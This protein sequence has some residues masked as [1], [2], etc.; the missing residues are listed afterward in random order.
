MAI[1]W[2][3]NACESVCRLKASLGLLVLLDP[4][5]GGCGRRVCTPPPPPHTTNNPSKPNPKI[6]PGYNLPTMTLDELAAQEVAEAQAREARAR[7]VHVHVHVCGDGERE[8]GGGS[9]HLLHQPPVN[10]KFLDP[11][12]HTGTRRRA[13][14]GP[15]SS[16]RTGRRTT[17]SWWRRPPT[18]TG[19]GTIGR[20]STRGGWGTRRG[21][22]F[23]WLYR[24][25]LGLV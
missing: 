14:G 11:I 21:S 7:C 17:P 16:R 13:P 8:I 10:P 25:C 18:T 4:G 2:V 20:T 24:A 3:G 22:D 12:P 6:R 5:G 15:R 1:F 9:F 19:R 23:E